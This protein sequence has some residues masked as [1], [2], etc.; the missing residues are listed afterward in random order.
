MAPARKL[1]Q[2]SNCTQFAATGI[3]I[4]LCVSYDMVAHHFF[5]TTRNI[6]DDTTK[7]V[8]LIRHAESEENHRIQLLF[9]PFR[10][11]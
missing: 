11:Y 5:P 1:V 4:N 9:L 3:H 8:Y 2:D 10:I 6:S 7:V